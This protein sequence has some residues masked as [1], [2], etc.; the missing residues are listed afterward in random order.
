MVIFRYSLAASL[1]AVAAATPTF[2]QTDEPVIIVTGTGLEATPAAPAY[3]TQEI[4]RDQLLSVPSGRIEDALSSVAGFQQFRRSDSRSANASAQGAT[5]RAL[6]GNA[7]SRAL[8]LLERSGHVVP[9]DHD[10]PEFCRVAADFLARRADGA[11]GS[12]SLS[13]PGRGSRGSE[14]GSR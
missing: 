7:T 11:T 3:D 5:L 12:A 10:G 8:V 1:I 4:D 9:V 2:A 6:G 13:A 14:S